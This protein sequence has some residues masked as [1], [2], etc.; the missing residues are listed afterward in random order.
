MLYLIREDL[1]KRPTADKIAAGV[2]RYRD[3]FGATPNIALTHTTEC[4]EIIGL[5][6]RGQIN[7]RPGNYW[8]GLTE[9]APAAPP[10]APPR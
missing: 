6:V 4:V 3:R 8:I 2:A 7:V 5:E 9:G 10:D 1:T